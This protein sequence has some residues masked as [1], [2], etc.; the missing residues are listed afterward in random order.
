MHSDGHRI[1]IGW[2][3]GR[4]WVAALEYVLDSV[5]GGEGVLGVACAAGAGAH[6]LALLAASLLLLRPCSLGSK[7][8]LRVIGCDRGLGLELEPR[9]GVC[10]RMY[11]YKHRRRGDTRI[12]TWE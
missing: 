2:T 11:A 8:Q 10:G 4:T 9:M 6:A 5:G 1:N 3:I 7:P 12:R